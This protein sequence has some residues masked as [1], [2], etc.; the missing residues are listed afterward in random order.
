MSRSKQVERPRLVRLLDSGNYGRI[1]RA[2]GFS[3]PHISRV[4]TGKRGTPLKSAAR[5][6]AAAGVS[7]DELHAW[8]GAGG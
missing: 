4:L 2:S 1:A 5:I 6:A 7:L 3:I 8:I